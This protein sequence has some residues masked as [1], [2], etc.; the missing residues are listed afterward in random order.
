ME[1]SS[2]RR[3]R[4]RAI[5]RSGLA[6]YRVP[7]KSVER[8]NPLGRLSLC[9]NRCPE[10]LIIASFNEYSNRKRQSIP[11]RFLHSIATSLTVILMRDLM[12][13]LG[14]DIEAL[15]F[16]SRKKDIASCAFLAQ[17][18]AAFSKIIWWGR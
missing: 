14:I 6:A 17:S 1:S 2:S 15:A 8:Q 18:S 7:S 11:Y 4:K 3:I 16:S 12:K 9:Q 13:L 10:P 5:N